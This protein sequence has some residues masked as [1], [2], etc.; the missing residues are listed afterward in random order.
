MSLDT[1]AH[2]KAAALDWMDRTSS[3][4]DSAACPDWVTLAEAKLN[5]EIGAIETDASLT[6]TIDSRTI[7][8][9]SLS[10]VQPIA[11]YV[12]QSGYD[13][14]PVQL[15]ANATLAR[16][17]TS[18]YPSQAAIDGTNLVFDRPLDIAYPFRLIYRQRFALSDSATTNWLLT[19]HADVYLAAVLMW[20]AGYNEAW[21]NGQVWKALLDEAIPSIKNTIAQNKR[22]VLRVDPALTLPSRPT[23]AQLMSGEF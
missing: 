4:S 23:N 22:G 15:Q 3:T 18:G 20:G 17:T 14:D 6:G 1:Y 11:L 21:P 9:S 12:A 13:E 8:I 7:D 2:L 19:N 5:R 10:L 16:L